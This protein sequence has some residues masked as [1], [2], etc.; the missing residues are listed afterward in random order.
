MTALQ[1]QPRG[2][3]FCP[4]LDTGARSNTPKGRDNDKRRIKT[5]DAIV[6]MVGEVHV[7]TSGWHYKHWIG[8]FYPEDI[9]ANA[10][11]SFY[12][13]H[14]D[15]VEINNTFYRLPVPATFDSWRVNSP[16]NFQFA[17]KANRFITHM[18]KLKDPETSNAKFFSAAEHLE[19]K[20]GPILFQLP[21]RW[22]FD[23]ARL[24]QFLEAL[25]IG[26]RYVFEIRDESWLVPQLFE[27]LRRHNAA[28][29]IHDLAQMQT[30]LEITADFTYLR[31]HGPGTAK[32]SGSYSRTELRLWANRICSWRK[33]LSAVYAYFNNDIGGHAVRNALA[34]RE[35][36]S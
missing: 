9:S 31:F 36:V 19:E 30:R 26:H 11:F 27:L 2:E 33:D 17:V 35:M 24:S 15:T 16:K 10:M 32:Y 20:L 12:A 22:G 4:S 6:I 25:P 18:K 23:R 21:P 28:F 8:S 34:I 7:G 1:V 5:D 13:R 3:S 14:F 29:C